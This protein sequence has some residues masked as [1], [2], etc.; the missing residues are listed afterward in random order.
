MSDKIYFAYERM[1]PFKYPDPR[2]LR[3]QLEKR[4]VAKYKDQPIS[5][6][7][8]STEFIL[9]S[10]VPKD[11]SPEKPLL[12]YKVINIDWE[13][14]REIKDLKFDRKMFKWIKDEEP[15]YACTDTGGY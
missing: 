8:L 1:E 13:E 11:G 6:I 10:I 9:K 5:K 15:D 12:K 4:I 3:S 14:T 2:D 7:T